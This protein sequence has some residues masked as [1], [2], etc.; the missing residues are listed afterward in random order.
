MHWECSRENN[1]QISGP[2]VENNIW[3]IRHNEER[4]TLPKEDIVRFIKSW[5]IQ[6]DSVINKLTIICFM[7]RSVRPYMTQ[8]SLVNIY[9]SVSF[10]TFIWY[11]FLGAGNQ[12]QETLYTTRKCSPLNDRVWVQAFM[13]KPL[14]TAWT[15]TIKVI[16]YLFGFAVCF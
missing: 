1:T 15:L 16:V 6:I 9:Y 12:Q 8:S 5:N 13:S 7:I 11:C 10:S 2:V 14:Q 3:R 4:N